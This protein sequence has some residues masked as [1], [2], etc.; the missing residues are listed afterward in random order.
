[1]YDECD[2]ITEIERKKDKIYE[3]AK[4]IMKSKSLLV[5]E[6]YTTMKRGSK[7]EES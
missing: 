6:E 5:N 2:F 7:E 4:E 1:M 3:K